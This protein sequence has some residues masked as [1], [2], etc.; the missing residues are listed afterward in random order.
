MR[1]VYL[2]VSLALALLVST[3]SG[4][5]IQKYEIGVTGMH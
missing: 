1:N 5:E 3:A 4:A 2:G